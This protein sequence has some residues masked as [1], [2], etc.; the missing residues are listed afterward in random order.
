[1]FRAIEK[2]QFVAFR[3]IVSKSD[4][5]AYDCEFVALAKRL[6]LSLFTSDKRILKD[7]SDIAHSLR[8]FELQ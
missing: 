4:C 3:G 7:F 2:S 5:S 1:M 8:D 6:N